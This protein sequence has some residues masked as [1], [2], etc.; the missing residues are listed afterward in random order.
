MAAK[1]YAT[2][3]TCK[4]DIAFPIAGMTLEVDDMTGSGIVE[5]TCTRCGT[6]HKPVE[7]DLVAR[8][9]DNGAQPTHQRTLERLPD[10][11]TATISYDDMLDFHI[12]I[13]VED[14]IAELL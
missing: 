2:C 5:F 1:V 6:V 11:G 14:C 8:L 12:A 4:T 9:M 10:S 7:A 13:A 3:P